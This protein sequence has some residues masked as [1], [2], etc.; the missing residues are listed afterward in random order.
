MKKRLLALVLG[1]TLAAALTAC[2]QKENESAN[3]PVVETVQDENAEAEETAEDSEDFVGMANPMVESDYESIMELTGSSAVLPEN[4]ENP[5]C[6]IISGELGDVQYTMDDGYREMD[7]RVQKADEFTDISGMYYEWTTVSDGEIYGWPCSQYA[8][9]DENG[10]VAVCLVYDE[11]NKIMYS[12]SA[13]AQ[14]L[15]GYD[16]YGDMISLFPFDPPLED[17]PANNFENR[18]GKT[19][20]ASYDELIGL[21]EGTEAYA[22][23]KVKGYDGEVLLYTENVYD[24]LDGNLAT[25]DATVYSKKANGTV[26]ADTLVSSQGTAYPLAL[27]SEGNLYTAGHSEV[28]VYCYGPNGTENAGLMMMKYICGI[29]F[30]EEGATTEVSGFYRNNNDIVTDDTANYDAGDVDALNEAF[31]EYESCTPI[32]FTAVDG[33]QATKSE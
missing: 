13:V 12:L 1:V 30:D 15:N 26:T 14:D 22:L 18:V 31:A 6:F 8:A 4:M 3:T 29:E 27:D 32:G 17:Y 2:G 9:E 23:V 11:G 10:D 21:L 16:I 19:S 25:I 7:F 33:R 28:S 20:F 5:Q 24:N